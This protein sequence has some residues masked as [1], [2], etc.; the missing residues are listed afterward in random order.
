MRRDFRFA[1]A[2]LYVLGL[3]TFP[4]QALFAAR[5]AIANWGLSVAPA[6]F[7]FMVM[8]PFLTG[9]EA[10]RVY[11]RIF[12]RITRLV[13][14]LPG[15][16][17]SAIVTGLCAG[18]PAGAMA[19][20]RVARREGLSP[21]EAARMA[22]IACGV[23]PIYVITGIGVA[24]AGDMAVGWRLAT[25]QLGALL[26]TGVLFR[27]AWRSAARLAPIP[28]DGLYT[29]K[30]IAQAAL[31][32]LKVGG[33][34]IMFAVGIALLESIFGP[35]AAHLAL[36]LD[37]PTG[38]A[39]AAA[40]GIPLSWVAAGVGF[41]GLCIAAQNMG[42]LREAGVTWFMYLLQKLTSAGITAGLYIAQTF[43]AGDAVFAHAAR[44]DELELA[45]FGAFLLALPVTFALA[46]AVFSKKRS[47]S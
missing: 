17:A 16:A 47:V 7:P 39:R 45:S 22:G 25:S 26:L 27:G 46:V 44:G 6:L 13:F 4:A 15:A 14:A 40:A 12:G 32:I 29:E 43:F 2:A 9:R 3:L 21:G 1:A 34:M 38:A 23:G 19:V 5:G 30:P 31:S 24:L 11:D 42:A 20:A 10:C 36:P 41:G 28:E 8:L 33:H 37:L 18:S 35:W